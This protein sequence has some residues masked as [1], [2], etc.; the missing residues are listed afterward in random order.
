M[1]QTLVDRYGKTAPKTAQIGTTA[2]FWRSA[3]YSDRVYPK[4]NQKDDEQMTFSGMFLG[5]VA[6]IVVGFAIVRFE[7]GPEKLQTVVKWVGGTAMAVGAA[8]LAYVQGGG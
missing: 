7:I 1:G 8:G 2:C 3:G 6:A 5:V 4:H